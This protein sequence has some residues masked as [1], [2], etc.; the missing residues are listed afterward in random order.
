MFQFYIGDH[1]SGAAN[2]SLSS[3]HPICLRFDSS[4]H[5]GHRDEC[6]LSA[7]FLRSSNNIIL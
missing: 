5:D 7:S 4:S 3:W 1:T 6:I 2:G